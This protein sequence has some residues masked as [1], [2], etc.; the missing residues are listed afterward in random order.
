MSPDKP[1]LLIRTNVVFYAPDS[2]KA[3]VFILGRRLPK[4]RRISATAY[5]APFRCRQAVGC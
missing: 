2:Y 3:F 1:T 4:G 5:F